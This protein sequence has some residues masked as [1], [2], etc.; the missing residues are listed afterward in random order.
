MGVLVG[1]RSSGGGRV[2][3]G[4]GTGLGN[5]AT[6]AVGKTLSLGVGAGMPVCSWATGNGLALGASVGD[7]TGTGSDSDEATSVAEILTSSGKSKPWI[8]FTGGTWRLSISRSFGV[9]AVKYRPVDSRTISALSHG[10]STVEGTIPHEAVI[11][12][13]R[14]IANR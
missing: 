5:E 2:S 12:S 11:S 13:N 9:A 4:T 14:W 8:S 7:V 6:F 3:V 10:R 1:A